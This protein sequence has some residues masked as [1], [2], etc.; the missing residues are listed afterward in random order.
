M[1]T[2]FLCL[3][4]PRGHATLNFGSRFEA[5]VATLLCL[6]RKDIALP[7]LHIELARAVGRE[8][9][10]RWRQRPRERDFVVS[11]S[12]LKAASLSTHIFLRERRSQ[13]ISIVCEFKTRSDRRCFQKRKGRTSV[14]ISGLDRKVGTPHDCMPAGKRFLYFAT[15]VSLCV[16]FYYLE[17]PVFFFSMIS[18]CEHHQSSPLSPPMIAMPATANRTFKIPS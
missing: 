3:R 15:I 16:L 14:V 8:T 12:S 1:Q 6:W 4:L 2:Q 18:C 17:G 10:A 7:V 11:I 5:S 13:Q 9:R